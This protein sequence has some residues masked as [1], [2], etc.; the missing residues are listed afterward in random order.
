MQPGAVP[1]LSALLPTL[2]LL[3][4]THYGGH[5]TDALKQCGADISKRQQG[6]A[7]CIAQVPGVWL[8]LPTQLTLHC[9]AGITPTKV[10]S[11]HL[12]VGVLIG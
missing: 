6:A 9:N 10:Y 5:L 8:T 1:H 11:T 3:R 4:P 2:A 7:L 12:A